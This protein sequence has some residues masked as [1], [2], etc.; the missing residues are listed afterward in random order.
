MSF[1]EF[2]PA[3]LARFNSSASCEF[4]SAYETHVDAQ[5]LAE[6]SQPSHRTFA[7]SQFRCDRR[8]WF[9]IRGVQPDVP[10]V[11]DR[12]T[13]FAAK[14]GTACHRILQT[15]IADMLGDDWISLDRWFALNPPKYE[16]TLT[17]AEDSLETFV[18]IINPPIRFACDGIIRWMGKYY[19]LE[20]KSHDFAVWNQLTDPRAEHIDQVTCYATELGLD[21]VLFLYIDRQFGNIKCYEYTVPEYDKA[22]I[23]HRMAKVMQAVEDNLA[24]EGL[25]K[26]DKYCT[27]TYCP[28]YQKCKEYS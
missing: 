16:Y 11:P 9:R 19:L 12:E 20:I 27:P 14:L 26:G 8:S 15:A 4:L 25:P 3:H 24:P 22:N 17:P 2:N 1:R 21:G 6:A 23:V 28:Y 13:D 10:Q 5:I 7:P 18:E